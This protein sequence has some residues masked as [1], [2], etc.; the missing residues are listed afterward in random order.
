MNG[1]F[2]PFITCT[3]QRATDAADWSAP[4]V[5]NANSVFRSAMA[6]GYS[7]KNV[8]YINKCAKMHMQRAACWC[9]VFGRF[10]S[11]E[12]ALRR[13]GMCAA[14]KFVNGHTCANAICGVCNRYW[15]FTK[16]AILSRSNVCL[17]SFHTQCSSLAAIRRVA[18]VLAHCLRLELCLL[19]VIFA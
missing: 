4:S 8:K 9:I 13:H 5:L 3:Q 14:C 1:I 15:R 10:G 19:A 6:Y 12:N 16:M 2:G 11:G 17:G 18:A 7:W